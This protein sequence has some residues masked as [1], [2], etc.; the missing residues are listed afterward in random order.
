M[1]METDL[2]IW[3]IDDVYISE[4]EHFCSMTSRNSPIV[5]SY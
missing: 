3:D 4:K 1:L 2:S 5:A